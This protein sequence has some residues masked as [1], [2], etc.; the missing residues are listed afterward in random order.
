MKS[1]FL[2]CVL[3]A[4]CLASSPL[5]M[6]SPNGRIG[7]DFRLEHEG[8]P[9]W[10]VTGPGGV[11][12]TWSP[13]G[14]T[15]LKGSPLTSHFTIVDSTIVERDE[16]YELVIGKTK[17][18]RDHFRELRVQLRESVK[19]YRRLD[20]TFR[21]Y[22]DGVAF[23]YILPL[24]KAFAEFDITKENTEFHFPLDMK[25]WAF[26]IN[27]FV[28]SYEGLYLPTTIDALPDTGLTYLPLTMQRP[29]GVTLAISEA[30]LID[31][32]GMYL[33]GLSGNALQVALSPLP[34]KN[35]ICVHGQTPFSSPW[36]VVMIGEKPGDLIESTIILN[37]SA[38]CALDDVSWIKPGKA[39]FPWW[40]NFFCD[41]PGVASKLDFENQKYY[42]DFA[43][44]NDIAYLELEPPWYGDQDDCILHPEKYDITKSIPELQLPA[45]F[46]YARSK[47]V[48]MFLW[49]HWNNVNRQADVAFPLFVKWGAAGVKIDFMNR[50]D[51]EMVNWYHMIL[52]KAAK[53]HLMVFFHG[54]YKPTGTQR[55]Y[56]HLLTQEG[57]LGNEQNKVTYLCTLEHTV[58]LPF[59]RMLAGPM[60]FT[61]G[62]FRNVTLKQFRP[63]MNQPMV[64]GTR[65][66]QLAMFVVYESPLMMVCDDPAAYR[67][68]PGL[69]FIKSVPTTWDESKVIEGKIAEEII[70]ARRSG[71]DWYIGGMTDW[72]ARDVSISLAFL[73]KGEYQAEIFQDLTDTRPTDLTIVKKTVTAQ[74]SISVHMARGGGLAVRIQK[75]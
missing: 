25:A 53:Y 20:I 39:I 13:L 43:S 69:E 32:A 41:K 7:I 27:T 37:L 51:Q 1:F 47:N 55:T 9:G 48:R 72:T 42:I 21:A 44:E 18:A 63:D 65:C 8:V 68:Q 66:H 49:T 60:D 54:A 38:P 74:S 45:L 28:S 52:K 15:F 5:H 17:K 11:I 16:T 34:G 19:P 33:R 12:L 50:D 46:D 40:P 26:Q 14:L 73:D 30:E 24:Q 64:L 75:R 36:R 61:P 70:I 29:D 2:L 57:V 71:A 23:R 59:T 10:K 35:G 4:S 22:D 31:Y 58:T 62:G 56:P 67:N 3:A 6:S